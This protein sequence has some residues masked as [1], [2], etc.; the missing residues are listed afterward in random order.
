MN[1]GGELVR[2]L[3]SL[4]GI[5]AL[6]FAAGWLSRRLQAR[7]T[8]GGRR[9]R[10]VEIMAVGAR[11]R[12]MIIDADGK[13]LLIGVGQGGMRTLHVY[14]G[15][16]P[17]PDAAPQPP[18]HAT[19]HPAKTKATPPPP[20]HRTLPAGRPVA[21]NAARPPRPAKATAQPAKP[22]KSAKPVPKKKDHESNDDGHR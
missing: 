16:A 18:I 7:A 9:M 8:P 20:A 4:V 2:V 21:G 5:V 22:E 17:A 12:L 11:D 6:I 14:E 1:V 15:V 19:V 13:R 10:C 3:L